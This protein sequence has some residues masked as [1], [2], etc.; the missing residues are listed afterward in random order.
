LGLLA[1]A[2]GLQQAGEKLGPRSPSPS[3]G[4]VRERDEILWQRHSDLHRSM[5]TPYGIPQYSLYSSY[6]IAVRVASIDSWFWPAAIFDPATRRVE[7]I[8]GGDQADMPSAGWAND[9][10]LVT[11]AL[12][13]RGSLGRFRLENETR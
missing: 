11:M 6:S 12:R 8:P 1:Y 7:R 5:V 3:R 13:A 9:G 2:F 4:F 10:R